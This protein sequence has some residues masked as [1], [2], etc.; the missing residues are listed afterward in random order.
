MLDVV[1][2]ELHQRAPLVFGAREEV[3]LI[4]SYHQEDYDAPTSWPLYGTRGLFRTH[5]G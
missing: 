1:P 2:V 4:E 5:V 3:K